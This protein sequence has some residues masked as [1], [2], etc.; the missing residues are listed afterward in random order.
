MMISFSSNL[1]DVILARV[2]ADVDDGFYADVGSYQALTHSNTAAL[3]NRGWHGVVCDPIYNFEPSWASEWKRW[4][5][6]DLIIRDMIGEKEEGES[7]YFLCNFRGLSTGARNIVDRHR[8]FNGAH[9]TE[10]GAKVPTTTLTRVLDRTLNGNTLHLV[11][12]DVEGMEKQVLAGLDF[13]KYQPWLF[14]IEAVYSAD[15]S[16][17]YGAWEPMLKEQGY[18][19]VYDDRV[20]RF[21]L[22]ESQKRLAERLAYPP[23]VLDNYVTFRQWE[24]ERRLAEYESNRSVLQR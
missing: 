1:E 11:C 17:S 20:N 24:L 16:P 4:R 15:A 8:E 2:F 14:C 5:P 7:E 13:K 22:H 6:R 10:E 3:Y 21:Y 18:S 23:N 9:I 12:I 19:P